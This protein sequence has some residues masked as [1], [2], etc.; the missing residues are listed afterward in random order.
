MLTVIFF[1][2]W[3]Q[4]PRIDYQLSLLLWE[5]SFS[6]K[7]ICAGDS[8]FISLVLISLF[9]KLQIYVS[10]GCCISTRKHLVYTSN[11]TC[12]KTEL[13]I[14]VT[15]PC[16]PS[17]SVCPHYFLPQSM[18]PSS[19]LF[20]WLSS[21]YQLPHIS[22]AHLTALS[23][24]YVLNLTMCVTIFQSKAISFFAWTVM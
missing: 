1:M 22:S 3:G 18:A 2:M 17:Q 10:D 11:I 14:F 23:P 20:F 6:L 19:V 4:S 21:S 13:L 12:L 7:T 8:Q 24:E 5:I 16:S 9:L 15:C